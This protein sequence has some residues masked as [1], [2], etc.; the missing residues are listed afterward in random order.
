[1][2]PNY[3]NLDH[4]EANQNFLNACENGNLDA[5]KDTIKKISDINIKDEQTG[6]TGLI[7]AA[8]NNHVEVVKFLCSQEGIDYTKARHSKN[9]DEFNFSLNALTCACIENRKGSHHDVVK[10]LL[11]ATHWKAL[12]LYSGIAENDKTLSAVINVAIVLRSAEKHAKKPGLQLTTPLYKQSEH[13]QKAKEQRNGFLLKL[14]NKIYCGIKE[15]SIQQRFLDKIET[16]FKKILGQDFKFSAEE[17]QKI[18]QANTNTSYGSFFVASSNNN[19]NNSSAQTQTPQPKPE[20]T[21]Q[22][23]SFN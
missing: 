3:Q 10:T 17:L 7:Y 11:E 21:A 1:M 2:K 23:W 16:G 4:N 20:D 15:P 5:V 9:P 18:T 6:C 22:E 19:N 8:S 14:A 12:H 13:L